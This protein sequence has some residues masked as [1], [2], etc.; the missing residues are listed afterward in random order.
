MIAGRAVVITW[1]AAMGEALE[2]SNEERAWHLF[3]A[4]LSVPIRMR[5]QPDADSLHLSSL[6][7]GERLSAASAATGAENF[8]RFAERACRLTNVASCFDNQEGRSKLEAALKAYGLQY[9][10][11]PRTRATA[12]ALQGVRTFVLDGACASAFAR[13]EAFIPDLR[14]P[15]LLMKICVACSKKAVSDAKAR[16]LFVFA[17]DS[18]RLSP[19]PPALPACP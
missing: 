10:G 2:Q 15:T 11:K 13:A 4:A 9:K 3:S 5:L 18:F 6:L 17:V 12:R 16:E 7:F 1:C 19:P 14:E 8:W